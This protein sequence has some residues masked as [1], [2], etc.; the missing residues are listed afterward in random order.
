M[1]DGTRTKLWHHRLKR[2]LPSLIRM[3]GFSGAK[4]EVSDVLIVGPSGMRADVLF[5]GDTR[6][7]DQKQYI[8]DV[9]SCNPTESKV[10]SKAASEPGAAAL[11]G[12]TQKNN[13]WKPFVDAQGDV[14]MALCF[15]AGGRMGDQVFSLLDLLAQHAHCT[16]AERDAFLNY[17]RQRLHIMNLVGV[18][19]VIRAHEPICEGPCVINLRG[20][21]DLGIPAPRPT[22]TAVTI[23]NDLAP[24]WLRTCRPSLQL[25]STTHTLALGVNG[26]RSPLGPAVGG[27]FARVAAPPTLNFDTLETTIISHTVDLRQPCGGATQFGLSASQTLFHGLNF[28]RGSSLSP[29]PI[30]MATATNFEIAP[31]TPTSPLGSEK[32]MRELADTAMAAAAFSLLGE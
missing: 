21:L 17:A 23:A 2:A 28:T 4:E 7:G 10:C 20:T 12:V 16:G 13:K 31:N 6:S 30:G 26:P 29:R 18:A 19:R 25:D 15:E 3:A 1:K 9:R 22:G 27:D 11:S 32:M 8:L 5:R 14:F 24:A